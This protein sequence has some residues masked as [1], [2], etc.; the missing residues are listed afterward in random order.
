MGVYNSYPQL[1]ERQIVRVDVD[2]HHDVGA[3]LAHVNVAD[4]EAMTDEQAEESE[5]H[6]KSSITQ[7]EIAT[8]GDV[9]ESATGA[10]EQEDPHAYTCKKPRRD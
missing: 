4:V 2:G 5:P 3:I 8:A 7:D 9:V 10:R 6:H 1:E